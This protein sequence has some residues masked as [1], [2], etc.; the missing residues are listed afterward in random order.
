MEWNRGCGFLPEEGSSVEYY[1]SSL[2]E[3]RGW[4]MESANG[5]LAERMRV[6]TPHLLPQVF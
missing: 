5:A 1:A 3:K 6:R 4:G 2:K